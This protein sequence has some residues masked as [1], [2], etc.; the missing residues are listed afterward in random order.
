MQDAQKLVDFAMNLDYDKWNTEAVPCPWTETRRKFIEDYEVREALSIMRERVEEIADEQGLDPEQ[1][2]RVEDAS[3]S[4]RR[5]K[6][7]HLG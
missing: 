1:L 3:T 2:R 5:G 6:V 7:W 4:R